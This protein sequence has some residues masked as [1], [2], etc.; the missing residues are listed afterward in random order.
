M[1]IFAPSITNECIKNMLEV[2][3][4]NCQGDYTFQKGWLGHLQR[5]IQY[6]P[7][8]NQEQALAYL[9]YLNEQEKKEAQRLASQP[10]SDN[11]EAFSS[12]S[13]YEE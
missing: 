8:L 10:V 5:M 13:I 9:A 3:G 4:Y 6:P 1:W 12:V 2:E 11:E 7:N